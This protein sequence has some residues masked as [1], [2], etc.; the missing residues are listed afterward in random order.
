MRND[1]YTATEDTFEIE[2]D[3][4]D[5]GAAS[6]RKFVSKKSDQGGDIEMQSVTKS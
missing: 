2:N 3:G 6:S 5:F 1:P 4:I